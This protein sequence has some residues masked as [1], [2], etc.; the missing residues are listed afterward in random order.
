M[1]TAINSELINTLRKTVQSYS[2]FLIE[3]YSDVDGK[4]KYNAVLSCMDW[5]DVAV[6]YLSAPRNNFKN[7]DE[8]SM[9]VHTFISAIDIISDSITQLHRVFFDTKDAPFQGIRRIFPENPIQS[10][11][12]DDEACF[13]NIRAVFGAHPVNLKNKKN[14]DERWFASWS[15]NPG[16][17]SEYDFSVVLY[18][19]IAG[20]Q[21]IPFGLKYDELNEYLISRYSYL[22]KII[23]KIESDVEAFEC[24]LK[25]QHIEKSENIV[26][27]IEILLTEAKRRYNNAYFETELKE[28]RE[29]IG[30]SISDPEAAHR[31]KMYKTELKTVVDEIYLQ[32]QTMDLSNLKSSSII[33]P[34]RP[35]SLSYIISKLYSL[36]EAEK[37]Q[38]YFINCLNEESNGE[39]L[40]SPTDPPGV[41]RLKLNILMYYKLWKPRVYE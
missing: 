1:E 15:G 24:T 30:C 19:N 5:I 2:Y 13:K 39:I 6:N 18:S 38:A 23:A 4:N 12:A 3:R 14:S 8:L 27:Q 40:L 10:N 34:E 32:L 26:I 41:T 17:R 20:Q 28:L 31:E 7:D 25:K 21:M 33:N 36:L 22:D 35:S 9:G 37:L 29:L 11:D 16:S